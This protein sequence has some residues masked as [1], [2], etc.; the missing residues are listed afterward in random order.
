M[1][2]GRANSYLFIFVAI[3]II[4]IFAVFT[5]SQPGKGEKSVTDYSHRFGLNYYKV[6]YDIAPDCEIKVEEILNVH[7]YGRESTGF[8]RDIPAN[9]G[10]QVKDVKVEGIKLLNGRNDVPYEVRSDSRDFITVDIGD[11]TVKTEQSETY[12]LTYTYRIGNSV[13]K[14]GLLPVVPVGTGWDCEI[15]KAEVTLILP[16]GFEYAERYVGAEGSDK[17]DL[18][19]TIT[20]ENGRQVINT[21]EYDLQKYEGITFDL[22][23]EKGALS[24]F[25]DFTPYY[26]VLGAAGLL[27]L[28]VAVK[29]LFFGRIK[30][31]P[32]VTFEA[33]EG[34]DP[35]IMGKYIDNRVNPEDV[36]ALIYYWADKG[37]I[38]LNLEDPDNPILIRLKFLPQTAESY[39][40]IV[41]SG[42]FRGGDS[43]SVDSLKYNFY[44]TYER[45]VANANQKAK[46][47]FSSVSV[48]ISIL[49]AVLAGLAAGLGFM[50]SAMITV[51]PRMLYPNGFAV[52]VPALVLYAISEAA[53]YE[54]LKNS[55]KKNI[56][57]LCL[58][59]LGIA[60]CTA[61]VSIL[62]PNSVMPLLPK[63]LFTALCFATVSLSVLIITRTK[64]HNS[65]LNMI[66][67]FRNF[68]LNA[69]KDRLEMLLESDPQYYYHVLPY[70][71]VL[72]VTDIWND[73]FR[74]L[75]VQP[76]EWAVRSPA[77][78]VFDIM[79]LNSVIRR[80]SARLAR[81]LVSRPASS[82]SNGFHHGSFGGHSGG[83]FG[84]GGGR[85][86]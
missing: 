35:L 85:G 15:D 6:T 49:F 84:G 82:G 25:F 42:L 46:N 18:N 58:I 51:S 38:K 1:K 34:M 60:L 17:S 54:K 12:R 77:E 64:E 3:F 80:S 45:A 66:V 10:A 68:I 47:L 23:F 70:A 21:V 2:S 79:I 8:M 53:A 41:F 20:E 31:T 7:Y 39:E 67:G 56:L 29:V 86:R 61:L 78:T 4:V 48:G 43:V 24:P 73:K 72:N 37:Y 36:T 65:R 26:F 75:T 5:L 59:I 11:R 33:P 14:S 16:A 71:Q 30:L 9:S 44:K 40:Q 57:F 50:I 27:L 28:T 13:V 81:E 83:G 55:K 63:I 74:D 76:P 69:E 62:I 19:Y 32:V 52:F 22:H